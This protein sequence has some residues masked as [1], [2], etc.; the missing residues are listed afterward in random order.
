MPTTTA[1]AKLGWNAN[2]I[3]SASLSVRNK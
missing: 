2:Q 1:A 3:H